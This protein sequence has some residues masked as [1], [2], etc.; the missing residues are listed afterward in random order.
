MKIYIIITFGKI[1]EIFQDKDDADKFREKLISLIKKDDEI[2]NLA[3]TECI[4]CDD[5]NLEYPEELVLQYDN[6]PRELQ[7]TE[8]YLVIR[9]RC[10]KS[11]EEY[12]NALEIYNTKINDRCNSLKNELL[13]N[14]EKDLYKKYLEN[15]LFLV[16][17]LDKIIVQ[18]FDVI[19][20]IDIK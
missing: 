19:E 7:N 12:R 17:A 20:K 3:E 10:D 6:Y 14:E 1:I 13:S 18:E 5:Y 11:L 15:N 2:S 4:N 8:E 9:N 16:A